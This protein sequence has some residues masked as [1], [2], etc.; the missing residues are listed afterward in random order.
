MLP[1]GMV[2]IK[3]PKCRRLCRVLG[4]FSLAVIRKRRGRGREEPGR[5]VR[6]KPEKGVFHLVVLVTSTCCCGEVRE[7]NNRKGNWL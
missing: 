2:G 7:G 5:E 6:Q 4:E 1:V 3:G